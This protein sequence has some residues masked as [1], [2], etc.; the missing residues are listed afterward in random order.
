MRKQDYDLLRNLDEVSGAEPEEGDQTNGE[1]NES[2]NARRIEL[3]KRDVY[4]KLSPEESLELE[5]L[6][7]RMLAYR[8][9]VAPLPLDEL[10]ELHQ[11]LLDQAARNHRGD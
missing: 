9:R 4:N 7:D 10:R 1:W 11:K 8:R 6:Q 3:V 5:R 2:L